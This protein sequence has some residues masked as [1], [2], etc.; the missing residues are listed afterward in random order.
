MNGWS[1]GKSSNAETVVLLGREN[2]DEVQYAYIDYETKD[3]EYLKGLQGSA[4]YKEIKA[5]IK[6]EY[7]MNVTNLYIAQIKDKCGFEKRKN[8][9]IGSESGKVPICPPEKEKA[10]LGAFKHF[11]MM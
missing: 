10:I 1:Q 8:Y 6:Q 9:Y 3:A 2:V 5:W 7:G 11:G 4:T